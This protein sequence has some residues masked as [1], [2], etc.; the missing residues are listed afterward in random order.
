MPRDAGDGDSWFTELRRWLL[1]LCWFNF[2]FYRARVIANGLHVLLLVTTTRVSYKWLS[3]ELM[4]RLGHLSG[5][6]MG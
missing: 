5:L 2:V 4:R 6:T 3:R 1:P